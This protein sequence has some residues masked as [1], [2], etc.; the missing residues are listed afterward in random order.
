MAVIDSGGIDWRG[1]DERLLLVNTSW[2][3]NLHCTEEIE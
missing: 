2:E 1:G 3:L